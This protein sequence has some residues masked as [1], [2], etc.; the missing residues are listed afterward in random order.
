MDNTA[1]VNV[2]ALNVSKVCNNGVKDIMSSWNTGDDEY[3]WVLGKLSE[4]LRH[5][6]TIEFPNFH[7]R[8]KKYFSQT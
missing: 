2:L 6:V 1:N 8:Q 7:D 4:W 5:H 3:E